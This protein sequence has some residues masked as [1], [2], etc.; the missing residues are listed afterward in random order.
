LIDLQLP[1]FNEY[2]QQIF[3]NLIKNPI[4]EDRIN[5]LVAAGGTGGHLFPALAVVEQ[6]EIL[7]NGNLNVQF[8]GTPNR[9]EAEKIPA[10]GYNFFPMPITPF[11]GLFSLQSY[12]LPF[13]LYK[14]I[15]ICKRLIKENNIQAVI[16]TGAYLSYPAGVAASKCGVPLILMESN[17]NPGKTIKMLANKASL[18]IT[19]FEE[20]TGYFVS[21]IRKKVKMLGNPVRKDILTLPTRENALQ[22]FELEKEKKTLLIFGGSLGAAS[23]NNAALSIINSIDLNQWQVIWQTGKDFTIDKDLPEGVKSMKFIDDMASAYAASDLVIS[24]SG[25]TTVA[26]LCIV[27]KPSVLVPYPSAS[28]N[29]QEENAG[30]LEKSGA[31]IL[32]KNSDAIAGVPKAFDDIS[33]DE[34]LLRNMG[35]KAF[36]LAQPNAAFNSAKAVLQI[37]SK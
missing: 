5:I 26:E 36:S 31:A 32:I 16:C 29:E 6:L 34:E 22:K 25:A 14:S 35:Q 20:T 2:L 8:A 23:I 9:I 33:V 3:V 1:N 28:N 15:S 4:M 24:R 21:D 13:N 10:L 27:G 11:K 7:T 19:S 37:I 18:I 12:L 30:V 17:V